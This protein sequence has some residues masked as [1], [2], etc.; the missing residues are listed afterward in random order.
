MP[1]GYPNYFTNKLREAIIGEIIAIN[2]YAEHIANSNM[3]AVNQVW[4]HI[5][6]DEKRHYGEFLSLLRKYDSGEYQEYLSHTKDRFPNMQMQEY[7]PD[8]D[9]QLILNNIREDIKGE[10]EAVILY[11][12]IIVEMP[13]QDIRDTFKSIIND[14]KEHTEHLTKL[15]VS[16]DKD[17]Y[18]GL[19]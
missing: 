4:Q 6:E 2:G 17:K 16:I 5:L 11:E 3:S 15:L 19:A 18:D 10:L 7:Q 12:Q 13:Y 9:K 1:Q 14:E 8:Y